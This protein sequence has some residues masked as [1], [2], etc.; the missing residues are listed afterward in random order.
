MKERLIGAAVL[1]AAAVILIPEMLSGPQ[2]EQRNAPASRSGEPPLKTY[3]ID[4]S[5]SPAMQG[6]TAS[7]ANTAPPNVIQES[8]PPAEDA[9]ALPDQPA[10]SASQ[11]TPESVPPAVATPPIDTPSN[12]SA[13]APIVERSGSPSPSVAPKPSQPSATPPATPLA[14]QVVAPV[15]EARAGKG[16]AVQ[17]GSFASQATADGMIKSLRTKG[18]DA[19]VMPV[20]SGAATLYRVRIGPMKDRDAALE[21]LRKV[22]EAAPGAAVVPHP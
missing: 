11:A 5:Q 2:R 21:I 8:A 22:K 15:P 4:L 6:S 19:F 1:V 14:T 18:Y 13:A 16:W 3:T 17:L 7:P 12:G 9:T 20:K 10:A